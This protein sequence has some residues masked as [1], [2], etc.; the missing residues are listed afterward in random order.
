MI[1]NGFK[2]MKGEAAQIEDVQLPAYASTKI[3]GVRCTIFGGVA[4]AASGEPH[5]NLFVQKWAQEFASM[6]EGLDGEIAVGPINDPL[7][8]KHT[9]GAINRKDGEPHFTFWVFDIVE[10][11][12]YGY[13][14]RKGRLDDYRR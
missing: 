10:P 13:Q 12:S 11:E 1:P 7:V 8:F 5:G 9:S 2:P 6:L 3:D 14:T 4:Y